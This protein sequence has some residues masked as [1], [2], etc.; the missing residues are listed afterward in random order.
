VACSTLLAGS[1]LAKPNK[2]IREKFDFC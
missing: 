1:S 2:K